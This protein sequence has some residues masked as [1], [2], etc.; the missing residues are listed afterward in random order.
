[1]RQDFVS[2]KTRE[3]DISINMNI[4]GKG[5]FNGTSG[6][7]FFDHMLNSFAVHGKMDIDLKA[8]GDLHVDCHHTVE[9]IGIVLGQVFNKSLGDKKGITRF[10][11]SLIPMDEALA[12]AVIDISGRPFLVFNAEFNKPMV[13]DFDT[14]MVVEFFRAF[15][16]NAG[17][18]LH[19]NLIYGQNAHHCI[20]AI[21]KAVAHSIRKAVEIS[22]SEILS[23]KG[24][25]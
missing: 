14:D 20:E 13:G 25:L 3:T 5:S 19:I 15:A 22:S 7:G 18:T 21:F 17:I 16:M 2:R 6:V 9:D 24:S 4:D 1:M 8:E 11:D 23:T 12:Q 10:G